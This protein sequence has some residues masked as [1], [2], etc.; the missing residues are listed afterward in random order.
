M[1]LSS[2]TLT[3]LKNF[4]S[5]NQNLVF[6]EGS[7]I[8]TIAEAK[9]L[10]A[11]AEVSETFPRTFGVYDINEFL[12][13]VGLLEDPELEFT[14]EYVKM[15]SGVRSIEYYYDALEM[16]TT[17]KKDVE[18]PECE[19]KFVLDT[20]TLGEI[21]KASSVLGISEMHINS[22]TNGGVT[23]S[24]RSEEI[25]TANKFK[26]EV[27]GEFNQPTF[28]F[29]LDVNNLKMIDGDYTVSLS[30]KLIS[31]FVNTTAN[32]EYWCALEKNSSYGE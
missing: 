25:E 12:S 26:V 10:F 23:L 3:V 14:E 18:M 9:N 24:I 13:T 21:R 1:K 32:L 8:R 30:S 6:N 7:K 27:D 20:R 5:I 11:A 4:A 2:E 29:V 17:P 15:S 22:N 16:L 31:H 19:V 28:D